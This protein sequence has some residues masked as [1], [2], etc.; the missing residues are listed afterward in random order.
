M[1]GP[2]GVRHATWSRYT[3]PAT[4]GDAQLLVALQRQ[5]YVLQPE[6]YGLCAPLK[7]LS[8][9]AEIQQELQLDNV[10]KEPL[11]R[12]KNSLNINYVSTQ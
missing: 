8:E 9:Y 4:C 7:E 5:V 11:K 12:L 1:R 10:T 3:H 6:H 2:E